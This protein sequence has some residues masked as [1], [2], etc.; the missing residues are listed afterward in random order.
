MDRGADCPSKTVIHTARRP[1]GGWRLQ[2]LTLALDGH[3]TLPST[4]ALA[5]PLAVEHLVALAIAATDADA[6]AVSNTPADEGTT[7]PEVYP[8]EIEAA[9][10]PTFETALAVVAYAVA[11]AFD[12]VVVIPRDR[13]VS[14]HPARAIISANVV[15]GTILGAVPTR[16]VIAW[17][18]A[19]ARQVGNPRRRI[20]A[21]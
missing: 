6:L 18:S 8:R 7:V 10:I 19:I 1:A 12:V 21:L 20:G 2:P 15:V 14:V 11:H 3:F 5:I 4:G 13:A 9:G 17:L 16:A